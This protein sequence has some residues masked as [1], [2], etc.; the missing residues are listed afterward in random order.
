M[1]R[2]GAVA[3]KLAMRRMLAR[4]RKKSL[5]LVAVDRVTFAGLSA[6]RY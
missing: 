6:Q 1:P 3:I 5:N 4:N 2:S